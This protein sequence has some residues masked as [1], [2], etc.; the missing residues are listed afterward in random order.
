[1]YGEL[2]KYYGYKYLFSALSLAR[3]LQFKIKMI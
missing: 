2:I 1:M 3:E